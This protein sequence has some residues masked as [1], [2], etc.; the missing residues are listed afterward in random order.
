MKISVKKG[1]ILSILGTN[2]EVIK[3]IERSDNFVQFRSLNCIVSIAII[4]DDL[5]RITIYKE[6]L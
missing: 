4:D 3:I 2:Y 6:N 5:T 1:Q